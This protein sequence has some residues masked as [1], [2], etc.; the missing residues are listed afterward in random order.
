M[1]SAHECPVT[2]EQLTAGFDF[3]RSVAEAIRLAGEIPA[4]VLYAV[5]MDK[6]SLEGF[7]KIINMLTEAGLVQRT[8]GHVLV[9]TGPQI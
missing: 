3:V 2:K 7:D 1:N 9:W 6:V 8:V 5:I 4:G